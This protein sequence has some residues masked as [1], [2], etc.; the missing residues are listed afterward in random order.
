LYEQSCSVKSHPYPEIVAQGR[1]RLN[2]PG[3]LNPHLH[4]FC[5]T[6]SNTGELGFVQR[7]LKNFFRFFYLVAARVKNFLVLAAGGQER[8]LGF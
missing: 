8:S 4:I 5:F 7:V 1:Y 2:D 3:N 6:G